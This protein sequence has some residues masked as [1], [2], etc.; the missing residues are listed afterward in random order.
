[1]NPRRGFVPYLLLGILTLGAGLGVGLGLSEGPVT[2]SASPQSAGTPCS[3][4]PN[5][6]GLSCRLRHGAVSFLFAGPRLSKGAMNCLVGGLDGAGTPA[7]IGEVGRAL[8]LLLPECERGSG[9]PEVPFVVRDA[10]RSAMNP[11]P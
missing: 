8:G 6:A 1:V 5:R 2:Y 3:A 9:V 11:D 7:N 10:S 4:S